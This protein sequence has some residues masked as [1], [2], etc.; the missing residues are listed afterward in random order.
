MVKLALVAVAPAASVTFTVRFAATATVGVPV[1][2]PV[3]ELM[4]SPVGRV[5][6][7]ITYIQGVLVHVPVELSLN[8]VPEG[9]VTLA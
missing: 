5:P 6:E 7:L 9:A 3:E 4:D 2:A 8:A 1:M